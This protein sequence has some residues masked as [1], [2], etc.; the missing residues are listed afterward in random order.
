MYHESNHTEFQ[1]QNVCNK[2]KMFVTMRQE[3][4]GKM[5]VGQI[6][7]DYIGL[8]KHAPKTARIFCSALI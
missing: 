8:E 1:K 4:S 5:T 6:L 7:V 2:N 3:S